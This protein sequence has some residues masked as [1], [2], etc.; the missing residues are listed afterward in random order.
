MALADTHTRKGAE[1]VPGVLLQQ[2]INAIRNNQHTD[3]GWTFYAV[4]GDKEA[5]EAPAEAELTGA[6][7]AALCGG[8]VPAGNSTIQAA[9]SFLKSDLQA[10]PLASG[11]FETEFGPNTDTN[12]WVV[13][14][15]NACGVAAQSAAFTTSAGK[16]PLDYLISQQFPGGAFDYSPSEPSPSFYSSQDALRALAGGGFTTVPPK[17][18]RAPQWVYEKQFST[19]PGV[20]ALRRW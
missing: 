13:Q 16:T 15:L 19:S 18:K 4:E 20:P 10:E 2:S 8:G 5:Q 9:I 17:P 6:T 14:G 3:G 1:R 11:A 12:A 7:I